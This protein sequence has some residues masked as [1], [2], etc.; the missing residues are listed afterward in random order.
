LSSRSSSN[1]D[2]PLIHLGRIAGH[3]GRGGEFTVRGCRDAGSWIEVRRVWIG[4]PAE[5][6][7]HEVEGCRAY[8]D[9]LVLKL[10]GIDDGDAA[11]RL[12]GRGVYV[13]REDAPELPEGVH[14][15]DELVGMLVV[16]ESGRELGRVEDVIETGGADVLRVGGAAEDPQ[17]GKK[18]DTGELMI[19]IARAYVRSI[20][21]VGRRIEVSVPRELL[22][23]NRSGKGPG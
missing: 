21:R 23:L 5:G 8:R 17:P 22:E 4:R 14:Y 15:I 6:R 3:R 16:D 7:F 2:E 19:P 10:K 18:D 13:A 12:K 20:D 1:R 11:A 9:R